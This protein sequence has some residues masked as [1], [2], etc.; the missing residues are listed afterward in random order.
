MD[1]IEFSTSQIFELERMRRAIDAT[2]DPE[3]LRSLT[4]DL[5]RAWFSEKASTN[6][7]IRAQ[8]DP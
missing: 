6:Q 8:L 1:A 7:A 4:K 5:L 2:S 3:A